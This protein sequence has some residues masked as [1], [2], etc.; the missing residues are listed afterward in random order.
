MVERESRR[1]ERRST[2]HFSSVNDSRSQLGSRVLDLQ[3]K[4]ISDGMDDGAA[5]RSTTRRAE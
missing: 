3:V 5:S 1:V 4:E 2:I